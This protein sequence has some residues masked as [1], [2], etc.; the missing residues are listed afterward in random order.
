[1]TKYLISSPSG[2]M[3]IPNEC[4]Q[5]VSEAAQPPADALGKYAPLHTIPPADAW[6]CGLV[7]RVA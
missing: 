5:A 2:A 1:M 3:V 4:L 6:S 7:S